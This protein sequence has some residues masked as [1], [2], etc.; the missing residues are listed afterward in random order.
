MDRILASLIFV[1]LMLAQTTAGA[2]EFS[3]LDVG[4]N[5]ANCLAPGSCVPSSPPLADRSR[6]IAPFVN[7]ATTNSEAF[8]TPPSGLPRNFHPWWDPWVRGGSNA[9]QVSLGVDWLVQSA[10]QNSRFV[11]AIQFDPQIKQSQLLRET[12]AFDWTSFLET[13][14]DDLNDPI[15]NTLTTGNNDDRFR[16]QQW[17]ARGGVRRRN[18]LGGEFDIAQRLGTQR[19]NSIFLDPNPQGTSRL[20]LNYTQP[21]LREA[22]RPYNQSRIVIASIDQSSTI[23]NVSEQLQDHLFKVTKAYWL[24]YQT[25]ARYHQQ[26]KLL[27]SASAISTNLQ[28]R[29]QVDSLYGQILRAQSAV[30]QRQSEIARAKTEIKNAETQ[31]KQ[32]VNDPRLIQLRGDEFALTDVPASD[33]IPLSMSDS[34]VT[35]LQYRPDIAQAIRT[36]KA[37]SVRLGVAR[38]ELLPR[39]DL[40]LGTY[41]AGLAD[42]GRSLTAWSQQ[43]GDG[44]PGYS[45]G[46]QF[47]LPVGNRAAQARHRE[48]HLELLKAQVV[49]ENTVEAALAEVEIAVR[50]V[51]TTYLEM[52]G[53]YHSMT[54]AQKEVNYLTD[55]YQTFPGDNATAALMLQNLLESQERLADEEYDF[56]VAQVDYSVSL[57]DLRRAMGT[58]MICNAPANDLSA[59]TQP[60]ITTSSEESIVPTATLAPKGNSPATPAPGSPSRLPAVTSLPPPPVATSRPQP[61]ASTRHAIPFGWSSPNERGAPR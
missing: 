20:E 24:L 54:A 26:N 16:D 61:Q 55:R 60:R 30:A 18:E 12:A 3:Q 36:I 15:G 29:S 7:R 47:E 48:R 40:I 25:R 39:L 28:E 59:I 2:Q 17:S 44:G 32:F 8:I 22:G 1:L 23:D 45:V 27:L 19:N 34:V 11:R 6:L 38:N 42:E 31:L 5:P 37:A 43:F 13:Q 53:K 52:V 33:Q 56:V 4:S 35:A 49:F 14:Y 50:E 10:L 58:L 21:L 57:I 41:V 46:L 9:Q 51:H